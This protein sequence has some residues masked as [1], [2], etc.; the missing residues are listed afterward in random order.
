MRFRLHAGTEP[1]A[2]SN[3]M[4]SGRGI[5]TL[6][7]SVTANDGAQAVGLDKSGTVTVDL[8]FAAKAEPIDSPCATNAQS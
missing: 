5:L 6:R 3:R 8:R 1:R 2:A 4:R 7:R